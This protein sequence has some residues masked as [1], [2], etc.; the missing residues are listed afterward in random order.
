MILTLFWDCTSLNLEHDNP[1]GTAINTQGYHD[2]LE[3]HLKSTIRP[4][5]GG[6]LSSGELL[7]RDNA[8]PHTAH[9][10]AQQITNLRF[11]VSSTFYIFIRPRT[12]DYHLSGPERNR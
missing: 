3:N 6:L 12:I 2:L 4:E 7:H 10:A 5:H 1:Q 9:A 11:L 8:Q